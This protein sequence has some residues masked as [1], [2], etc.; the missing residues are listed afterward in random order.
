MLCKACKTEFNNADHRR[1]YCSPACFKEGKRIRNVAYYNSDKGKRAAKRQKDSS[2]Y[3]EYRSSQ[4]YKDIEKRYNSLPKVRA[5][6]VASTIR[7]WKSSAKARAY[8]KR[9]KNLYS[10]RTTGSLR[11]WW[12]EVSA[13]GCRA[14]GTMND[15]TVDHIVSISNGGTDNKENLQVLCRGCNT[16]K[17][18]DHDL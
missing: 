12:K 6:R 4:R 10:K 9:V 8:K 11:F 1:N 17:M 14:C 18:H 3:K 2:R 13:N 15:L 5:A 7:Y 16:K